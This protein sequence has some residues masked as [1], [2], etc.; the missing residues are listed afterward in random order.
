MALDYILKLLRVNSKSCH[1][2]EI[3]FLFLF[4]VYKTMDVH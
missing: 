4:H 3:F 1:Y 2:Q